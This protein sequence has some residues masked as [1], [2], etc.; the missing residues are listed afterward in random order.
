MH[1]RAGGIHFLAM[2]RMRARVNDRAIWLRRS[3][4]R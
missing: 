4:L 2:A 1:K 3:A